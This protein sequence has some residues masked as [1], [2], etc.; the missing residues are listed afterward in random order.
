[1]LADEIEGAADAGEHAERQH[2]DLQQA[3]RG[4]VV[5]VPFDEGAVVH[6]RV[7]DGHDLDQ[8]PARQHEAA[9]V[10]RQ[11]ARKTHQL[12]RQLQH[13]GEQ[14]IGRIEASGA[15]VLFRQFAAAGR[16]PH[17]AGERGDGI[18]GKPHRLADVAHGRAGAIGD[19]GG[20][21]PGAVAAVARVDVL[22]HLL[23]PLVL[24]VDV[25]V[26]RLL[27]L[28]RHEAVEQHIDLGGVHRR[29][30]E[31]VADDGVGG[32]AAPLAEDAL[33]AG[34]SARCRAR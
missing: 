7:A 27:A 30:G 28:G 11:V 1:M 8:R 22:D 10:L 9:D 6:R 18:L 5:L 24:E 31:A 23:A 19:D 25:D 3:E 12:V 4:D 17:H 13:G 16:A 26:G 29:D 20:G 14:R 2:V 33:G 32:R 15:H 34:D 21:E